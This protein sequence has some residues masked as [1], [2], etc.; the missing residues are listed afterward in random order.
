MW[1][2]DSQHIVINEG[3]TIAVVDYDGQNKQ[4][5]YSGPYQKNFFALT[6][7]GKIL[8]LANLNPEMNDY[9]DI[10]AVGIR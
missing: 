6:T 9:P 2:P 7:D 5:V 4:T 3:K 10:Y 1:Y 8:G